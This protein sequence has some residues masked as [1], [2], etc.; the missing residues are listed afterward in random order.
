MTD[1][2]DRFDLCE[3]R[4][5]ILDAEGHILILGG[6]GAGKTTIGLLKARR[7]VR[8]NLQ[9]V[10]S[11]LFLSF[12]NSAV[13][14]IADTA[15]GVLEGVA[16]RQVEI[17]TYHSFAWEILRAH[18]Y[19]LSGR[20]RLKVIPAQDADILRAG[21]SN[22]AWQGEQVRLFEQEGLV[23]Y[24]QFAPRAAELLERCPRIRDLFAC[25]YPSILVDEFQD[26]DEA[27]WALLKALSAGSSIAALGDAEQRI[28]EWRPG[29]S[30]KRLEDFR[31]EL[32]PLVFD[33]GGENHRSPKTG[34][35]SFGRAL[36]DPAASL[37]DC[38]EVKVVRFQPG[39]LD[40]WIKLAT[41]RSLAEA[42]KRA[43][44]R[45]ISV[46]VAGRSKML[47]R[48][49]SDSLSQE[50]LT[51]NVR[52]RRIIHDVL[53]DQSQILLA[54]RMAAFLLE[55]A[56]HDEKDA[57]V[58]ALELLADWHRC[59]GKAS[60]IAK[61]R[62]IRGWAEQTRAGKAVSTKLVEAV[63]EAICSLR[64]MQFTGSPIADWITVRELIEQGDVKDLSRVGEAVRFLRVLR[65]GSMI[66]ENLA[67]L[68]RRQEHYA[69]AM[70][71]VEDAILRD[72]LLDGVRP[73][74]TCTVMTMHQLKGREFDAVVLVE[75]RY[76][77]F[78]GR[79]KKPPFMDTR[80]LLQ[81][82]VTRAR[83]Y[84]ILLIPP[85]NATFDVLRANSL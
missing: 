58:R 46:A 44:K 21:L 23:T 79:D 37:P 55:A 43:G 65:R 3:Q 35:A 51:D 13:R 74:V 29:V 47:V 22:E 57:R 75:D 83:E 18:G 31:K 77:R 38:K 30:P 50:H 32:E 41:K 27:Q 82:A 48:F 62:R 45:G 64:E 40:L 59:G 70:E 61:A 17:K 39:Q 9:T 36:L 28:Y 67:G 56:I 1:P 4:R 52:H 8:A 24:D 53:I 72:Q 16:A 20:R 68:W 42:R 54:A 11:V 60:H 2:E 6:P 10:Q 25:A 49:I 78:L 76:R 71:A 73:P 5:G 66:E 26:T 14:R 63:S 84:A 15:A 81:V 12:S 19:L 85:D 33:F 7:L 69:G 80:R 34:I